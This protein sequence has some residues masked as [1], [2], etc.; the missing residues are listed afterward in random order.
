MRLNSWLRQLGN[1]S[2]SRVQ[3]HVCAISHS[4]KVYLPSKHSD[5][6]IQSWKADLKS[7]LVYKKYL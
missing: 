6:L 5:K 7:R 3:K 2:R 4:I 1:S